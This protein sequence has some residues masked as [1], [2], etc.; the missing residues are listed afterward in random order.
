MTILQK[1]EMT[2]KKV[3]IKNSEAGAIGKT[4]RKQTGNIQSTGLCQQERETKW[5]EGGVGELLL[6]H[7][8]CHWRM[9]GMAAENRRS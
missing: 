3:F 4:H 1:K 2:Q 7:T 6:L 5:P 9:E 8:E